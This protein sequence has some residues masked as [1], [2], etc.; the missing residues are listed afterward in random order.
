[1]DLQNFLAELERK[2]YSLE[3]KWKT[4][5]T[6]PECLKELAGN[7]LNLTQW[8]PRWEKRFKILQ[9]L[10]SL[11][12]SKDYDQ[13][14]QLV[15]SLASLGIEAQ[16][17]V[18]SLVLSLKESNSDSANNA[19]QSLGALGARAKEAV[20]ALLQALGSYLYRVEEALKKIALEAPE[21]LPDLIQ[22]LEQEEDSRNREKVVSILQNVGSQIEALQPQLIQALDHQ[23]EQISD[24]AIQVLGHLKVSQVAPKLLL[25]FQ[26]P[27]YQYS[28]SLH[29]ALANLAKSDSVVRNLLLDAMQ[30]PDFKIR[31]GAAESLGHIGMEDSL[32]STM[33]PLLQ[34]P[35]AEKRAGAAKVLREMHVAIKSKIPM[36]ELPFGTRESPSTQFYNQL[37][38]L[39]EKAVPELLPLIQDS[40]LHVAIE[41]I[42]TL[43]FMSYYA[44]KAV[45][46]LIQV[47]QE[48]RMEEENS[49]EKIYS[50]EW[51]HIQDPQIL[52]NIKRRKASWA[53]SNIPIKDIHL[54]TSLLPWIQDSDTEVAEN[55]VILFRRCPKKVAQLAVPSLL[56]KL[57][58]QKENTKLQKEIAFTLKEIGV[59]TEESL[60]ILIQKL[61][62][63]DYVAQ[64]FILEILQQ[65]GSK[66]SPATPTLVQLLLNSK[67]LYTSSKIISTLEKIGN[68]AKEAIPALLKLL[69]ES[70]DEKIKDALVKTLSKIGNGIPGFS[71]ILMKAFKESDKIFIRTVSEI[72]A[73][74]PHSAE[75][76]VPEILSLLSHSETPVRNSAL[77]ILGEL[78][79][80]KVVKENLS[81]IFSSLADPDPFLRVHANSVL[82]QIG[83]QELFP[84]LLKAIQG[85]HP[86]LRQEAIVA[87]GWMGNKAK[88]FVDL[89]LIAL[90][91]P[92]PQ[93]RKAA[94]WALGYMDEESA[95][96]FPLLNNSRQDPDPSVREAIEE[97]LKILGE[98]S[99]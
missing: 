24:G 67:D 82:R 76:F 71:L 19:A 85:N 81:A 40:N 78:G 94:A 68:G 55:L 38:Q 3:E 77:F 29:K 26:I 30:H 47:L 87:L 90:K 50:F 99:P 43:G 9:L 7:P 52:Q 48:P 4:I 91:D 86:L 5:S 75:E 69:Q 21:I 84:Y 96:I 39:C 58:L 8:D 13:V 34:D 45:S 18:P 17:A 42:Y 65:M 16:E 64:T 88:E 1:M 70:S 66:A 56:E 44:D 74:M 46:F 59:Q 98:R 22:F 27:H 89:I 12:E 28:S 10:K 79:S 25:M 49:P 61:Q 92:S 97:S 60:P 93:I 6:S 32:L 41:A 14:S 36:C 31:N 23:N 83:G 54:L 95:K 11:R 73:K 2:G 51:N 72:L 53:L 33:L 20:P 37:R 62:N 15:N 35:L 80:T 57:S 63:L